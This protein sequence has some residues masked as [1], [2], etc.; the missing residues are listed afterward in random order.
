MEER[1]WTRLGDGLQDTPGCQSLQRGLFARDHHVCS[2]QACVRAHVCVFVCV[3]CIRMCSYM[4]MPVKTTGHI[5]PQVLCT[6]FF[7]CVFFLFVFFV[8]VVVV[9]LFCFVLYFKTG[10]PIGLN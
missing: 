6:G 4:Y 3:L 7:L 1:E 5:I 9:G 8:V 10:T 2:I